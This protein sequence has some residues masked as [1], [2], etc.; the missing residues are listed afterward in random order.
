M[1][2]TDAETQGKLRA[3]WEQQM[4]KVWP[5]HNELSNWMATSVFSIRFRVVRGW[6]HVRVWC[7]VHE[8]YM[9]MRSGRW[10]EAVWTGLIWLGLGTSEHGK[11][12]YG[13]I[14][15]WVMLEQLHNWRFLKK[16]PH[17]QEASYD[18]SERWFMR[19]KFRHGIAHCLTVS[20]FF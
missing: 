8:Q 19:K 6:I 12:L 5:V 11:E 4:P 13:S 1:G 3:K 14:R 15:C 2:T 7:E 10:H 20:F 18:N 16:S 9:S 17:I